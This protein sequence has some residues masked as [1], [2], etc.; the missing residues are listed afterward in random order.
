MG[1]DEMTARLAAAVARLSDRQRQ[2]LELVAE[3]C[4]SKQIAREFDLSPSTVDN[5]LSAAVERMGMTSRAEAARA[6]HN[7][8]SGE[9]D[10]TS[11]LHERPAP[12]E[13]PA[14][15]PLARDTDRQSTSLL[16]PPPIGG[17][18]NRLSLGRRYF[19]VVQ[20]AL[21]GTMAMT[22]VV[23]TIAGLVQLFSK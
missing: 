12:F 10:F 18:E 8:T 3:G 6:L 13:G 15:L 5:H 4:T 17:A 9:V 11:A 22:A 19:H 20:I 16:R 2:C 7:A 23:M 14:P 1:E 21:L